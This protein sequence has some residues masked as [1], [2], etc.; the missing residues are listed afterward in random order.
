MAERSVR[1]IGMVSPQPASDRRKHI[2]PPS[3]FLGGLE[4]G[5]MLDEAHGGRS[6]T[7]RSAPAALMS[8]RDGIVRCDALLHHDGIGERGAVG[9]I[10]HQRDDALS[11]ACCDEADRTAHRILL[12]IAVLR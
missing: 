7:S 12:E 2:D 8:A 1:A 4:H 11:D 3:G 10:E 5:D 6:T 9:E